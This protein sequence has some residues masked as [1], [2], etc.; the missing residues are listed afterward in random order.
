M[1]VTTPGLSED[2][3]I[4]TSKNALL[5]FFHHRIK[6]GYFWTDSDAEVFKATT[7]NHNSGFSMC[8]K[9]SRQGKGTACRYQ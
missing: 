3:T 9:P 8:K 5:I 6:D 1:R 4:E 7:F 2:T